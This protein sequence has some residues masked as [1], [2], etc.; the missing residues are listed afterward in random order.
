M[1][2]QGRDGAPFVCDG[3]SI[4]SSPALFKCT[5]YGEIQFVG[6]VYF[7]VCMLQNNCVVQD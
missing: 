4:D 6:Q 7:F 2:R 1:A 3:S 5:P